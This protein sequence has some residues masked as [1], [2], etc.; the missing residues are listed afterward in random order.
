MPRYVVLDIETDGLYPKNIW[1]CVT[2]DLGT[3]E[4]R[5]WRN[6][7]GL[8]DY[9]SGAFLVGHNILWFDG[10]VLRNLWDI[11]IDFLSHISSNSSSVK[12]AY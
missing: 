10:P 4:K 9:L 11:P 6:R 12:F 8:R 5:R 3:G 2:K 1:V 7:S